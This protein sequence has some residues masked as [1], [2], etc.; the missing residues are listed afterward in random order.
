MQKRFNVEEFGDELDFLFWSSWG[1]YTLEVVFWTGKQPQKP[2]SSRGLPSIWNQAKKGVFN[3]IFWGW[4]FPT[5]MHRGSNSQRTRRACEKMMWLRHLSGSAFN[6][7]NRQFQ[8]KHIQFLGWFS[9]TDSPQQWKA[10]CNQGQH[11]YHDESHYLRTAGVCGS[12]FLRSLGWY[13]S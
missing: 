4:T 13:S 3:I 10:C 9:S 11:Q 2:W 12:C 7:L 6:C 1:C 5:F 8:T